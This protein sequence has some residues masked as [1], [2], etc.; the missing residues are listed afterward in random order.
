MYFLKS[1]VACVCCLLG[2]TSITRSRGE[3]ST[4]TDVFSLLLLVKKCSRHLGGVGLQRVRV[5]AVASQTE[6]AESR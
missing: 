4:F 2:N 1:L 5:P 3:T 6:Q